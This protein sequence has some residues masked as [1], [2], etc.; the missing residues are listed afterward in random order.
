MSLSN[1]GK[2]LFLYKDDYGRN[3]KY[4][5]EYGGKFIA[6]LYTVKILV[7]PKKYICPSTIDEF[8]QIG[9]RNCNP[10]PGGMSYAGRKNNQQSMYPGLYKKYNKPKL[11]SPYDASINT[12]LASDDWENFPNHNNGQ[13]INFL[14][15]DGHVE[16]RLD[17]TLKG[18]N[19]IEFTKEKHNFLADPLTN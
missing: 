18:D 2:A 1:I 17:T 16:Q 4:P 11:Y 10:K 9:L 12:T 14:F 13:L 8:D 6:K 5:N 3:I 15:T 7:E 19:Y